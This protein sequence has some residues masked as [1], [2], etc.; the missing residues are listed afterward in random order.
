MEQRGQFIGANSVWL[1]ALAI[2]FGRGVRPVT[3]DSF[4]TP[5]GPRV[6]RP[7]IRPDRSDHDTLLIGFVAD[8]ADL[9]R[10]D[11]NTIKEALI[12]QLPNGRDATAI[13]RCTNLARPKVA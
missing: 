1:D 5:N 2:C 9:Y 10:V 8:I 4:T 12:A 7:R 11:P 13:R 6:R 3:D